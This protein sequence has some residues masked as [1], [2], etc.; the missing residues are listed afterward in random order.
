MKMG[1]KDGLQFASGHAPT[2]HPGFPLVMTTYTILFS[3]FIY[4]T[5]K[6]LASNHY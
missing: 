1:F 6:H 5:L 3:P 4:Y 2:L